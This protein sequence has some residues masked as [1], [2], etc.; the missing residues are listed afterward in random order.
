MQYRAG[1]PAGFFFE[2]TITNSTY[3]SFCPTQLPLKSAGHVTYLMEAS[4]CSLP[5][6]FAVKGK[7]NYAMANETAFVEAVR[8]AVASIANQYD[9]IVFPESRYPFLRQVTEGLPQAREL[10][11]RAK[12]DVCARTMA[13]RKWSKLERVSQ[14]RAWAE[15]GETFTINKVKSNQ[16]K[17]Y[18][19]HIFEELDTA[20]AQRILLLDDFIMSGNTLAAMA[21]SLKLDCYEAFGVFYQCGQDPSQLA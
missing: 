16:R 17:H 12:A 15:M 13:S 3:L 9:L 14:E 7:H 2:D 18:A 4:F 10:K 8:I 6:Y 20:G 1:I 11:K 21:A 5:L 19:P